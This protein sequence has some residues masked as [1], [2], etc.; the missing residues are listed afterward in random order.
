M[1]LPLQTGHP[2]QPLGPWFSLLGRG[3][4]GRPWAAPAHVSSDTE[5]LAEQ[6]F[7]A[8]AQFFPDGADLVVGLFL[9]EFA[10]ALQGHDQPH[11]FGEGFKI[12]VED[13]AG[14]RPIVA[15]IAGVGL[16][17]RAH[18]FL[19]IF[20]LVVVQWIAIRLMIAQRI[21]ARFAIFEGQTSTAS[22]KILAAWG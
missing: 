8:F 19:I 12:L 13:Q 2:A 1:V 7:F 6:V 16:K 3:W 4:L 22:R 21:V 10:V 15:P 11:P 9:A 18:A 14:G 20:W 5:R 17:G